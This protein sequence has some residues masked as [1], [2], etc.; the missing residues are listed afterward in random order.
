MNSL[1]SF[2]FF[3]LGNHSCN[4]RKERDGT[5]TVKIDF[6]WFLVTIKRIEWTIQFM[7]VH[8]AKIEY[9]GKAGESSWLRIAGRWYCLT[10]EKRMNT[11]ISI[12]YN[13]IYIIYNIQYN[14]YNEYYML[15]KSSLLTDDYDNDNNTDTTQNDHH[16]WRKDG[17]KRWLN[18]T[19]QQCGQLT[20]KFCHQY[21]RFSL[22]AWTSNC[23]APCCNASARS[24]NSDSFWS[25]S[26]TFSTFVFMIPTTSSTCACVCCR[27]LFG[28]PWLDPWPR[29]PAADLWGTQTIRNGSNTCL[30]I[31][32]IIGNGGT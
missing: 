17:Y 11:V 13:I 28:L 27:R 14:I 18:L 26:N 25:L 2:N 6:V 22:V 32:Y 21:F 7:K 16:L 3:L 5:F 20:F 4:F 9:V 23:E 29:S 15:A 8:F 30:V 19:E 10:D 24:S 31:T 12:I 1:I